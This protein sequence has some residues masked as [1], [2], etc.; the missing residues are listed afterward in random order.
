MAKQNKRKYLIATCR[1]GKDD[2]ILRGLFALHIPNS[3]EDL[4]GFIRESMRNEIKKR[5]NLPT[6]QQAPR[7]NIEEPYEISTHEPQVK[8]KRPSGID[9]LFTAFDEE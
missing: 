2:D 5:L 1:K 7:R 3:K 9:G 8:K 4:A 6:Q